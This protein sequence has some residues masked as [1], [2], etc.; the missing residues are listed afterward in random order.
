MLDFS[1]G[2]IC[3]NV[4]KYA[5]T[6]KSIIRNASVMGH[7]DI[8][9]PWFEREYSMIHRTLSLDTVSIIQVG[10]WTVCSPRG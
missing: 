3:L 10:V 2:E 9:K 1:L 4:G 7:L 6:V 5:Y 8:T